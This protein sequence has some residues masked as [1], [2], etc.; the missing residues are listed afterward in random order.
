MGKDILCCVVVLACLVQPFAN[1]E[2]RVANPGP[3]P[4]NPRAAG[5][6]AGQ[7]MRQAAPPDIA[8]ENARALF[9]SGQ[10]MDGVI[11]I[12]EA[13]K[14]MPEDGAFAREMVGLGQ[15]F[16]FAYDHLLTTLEKRQLLKEHLRPGATIVE[17]LLWLTCFSDFDQLGD[18][19]QTAA[20][21]LYGEIVASDHVVA[22]G[23]CMALAIPIQL[24]WQADDVA[25]DLINEISA[26]ESGPAKPL[27]REILGS[28]LLRLKDDPQRLAA[29]LDAPG[30]NAHLKAMIAQSG[31]CNTLRRIR[32]AWGAANHGQVLSTVCEAILQE[33]DP[34]ERY[35]LVRMLDDTD[36]QRNDVRETLMTVA[37]EATE[38]PDAT[39]ARILLLRDTPALGAFDDAQELTQLLLQQQRFPVISD[40]K[41]ESVATKALRHHAQQ[42]HNQG[43]GEIAKNIRE[44]LR[45]RYP[46]SALAKNWHRD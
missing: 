23:A 34:T 16:K 6:A 27:T 12:I 43:R 14:T 22:K 15:A 18:E 8:M 24:D 31:F 25:V 45:A 5:S 21:T 7:A 33:E 10:V 35:Y 41:L 4:E 20:L 39:L 19:Q 17:K 28:A 26:I 46:E 37:R 44:S 36:R 42:L 2:D 9:S 38:G 1:G 29:F 3:G 13:A 40:L 32:G 30:W 11:A